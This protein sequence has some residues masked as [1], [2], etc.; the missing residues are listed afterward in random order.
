VPFVAEETFQEKPLAR[1]RLL[2]VEKRI[3]MS[4]SFF[5]QRTYFLRLDG[6]ERLYSRR[7]N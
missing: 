7:A 4:V 1:S 5:P 2:H 3:G 6:M